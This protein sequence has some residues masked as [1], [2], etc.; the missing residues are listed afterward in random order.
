M[1]G[2]EL[3]KDHEGYVAGVYLD[4]LG[5]PT[6][7]YGFL[8]RKQ[9]YKSVKEY[10]DALFTEEYAKAEALYDKLGLDLDDIRRAAIVDMC[11]QLGPQ[12][13]DWNKTLTALR[14]K[15]WA[16]AAHF[17]EQALWYRQ[18]GRRGKRICNLIREGTWEVL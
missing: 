16:Q 12:F 15:D 13:L 10:H 11:Y 8:L 17:M 9:K 5:Y 4:S 18:S 3:T 7:G 1:N 14:Q 6:H 2:Q